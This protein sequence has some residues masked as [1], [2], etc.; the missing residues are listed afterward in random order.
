MQEVPIDFN[1]SSEISL[2]DV[3]HNFS[4]SYQ[5][6]NNLISNQ[7]IPTQV[8][9][10]EEIEN[11]RAIRMGQIMKQLC[12]T[13]IE[14]KG[15]S[16]TSN[17]S[18]DSNRENREQESGDQENREKKDKCSLYCTCQGINFISL[19]GFCLSFLVAAFMAIAEGC[20]RTNPTRGNCGPCC[21]ANPVYGGYPLYIIMFFVTADFVGLFFSTL[22]FIVIIIW[23]NKK[24][25]IIAEKYGCRT[26]A[27]HWKGE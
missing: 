10:I 17:D 27:K 11:P 7:E 19:I 6:S 4:N 1:D 23:L 2:G 21:C 15:Y 18:N 9:M 5:N 8:V 22:I 3:P 20:Y 25:Y 13:D 16:N 26:C 12:R 24:G 14:F